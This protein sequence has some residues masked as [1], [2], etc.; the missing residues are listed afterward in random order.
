[1]SGFMKKSFYIEDYFWLLYYVILAAIQ[2]AWISPVLPPMFSRIGVC[3]AIFAPLFF[4]YELIPFAIIFM[5]CFN[6]YLV[7]D[8]NY[9]PNDISFFLLALAVLMFIHQRRVSMKNLRNVRPLFILVIYFGLIDILTNLSF[10]DCFMF[11]LLPLFIVPF[12]TTERSFHLMSVGFIAYS[13]AL[14][15]YYFINYKNYLVSINFEDQIER[16]QWADPNYMSVALG[17]GFTI[18]VLYIMNLIESPI[19]YMKRIVLIPCAVLIAATIIMLASRGGFFCMV[20]V[21]VVLLFKSRIKARWW[22]FGA[23]FIF[24][25]GYYLL[26]NGFFDVLLYRLFEEGTL[27]SG[28]GRQNI[29]EK[30]FH[31]VGGQ[32]I[33]YYIFGGGYMHRLTLSGGLDLHNDFLSLFADYG[34]IGLLCYLSVY[35][36]LLKRRRESIVFIPLLFIA[37]AEFFVSN[38]LYSF[39]SFFFVWIFFATHYRIIR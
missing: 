33:F 19:K 8:Y 18:C 31:S 24:A 37:V 28:D 39:I 23:I 15:V 34:I 20:F 6:R 7:T 25:V 5:R 11:A 4:K 22:I 1:M 17:M 35:F 29:W 13:T 16:A 26:I 30:F 12:I 14:S 32:N 21:L 3:V 2:G 36:K 27:Q 10:G 38:F 9:L